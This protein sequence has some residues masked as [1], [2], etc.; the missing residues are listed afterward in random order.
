MTHLLFKDAKALGER[1][2]A[3]TAGHLCDAISERG[4]ARLLLSTGASQLTTIDALV[5]EDVDWS[6]VEVFHLD[7]YVGLPLEHPASFQKYLAERFIARLPGVAAMHYV[8]GLG[9][10]DE[11]IETLTREIRR[12]PIDV[13]LIGIGEN[14][15]IGFN[16]PPADFETEAAFQVVTL[17]SACKAQQ[18]REGWFPD[19]DAVP[20]EAISITVHQIL[21]A[22][23]IL[24]SV[25]YASKATAVQRT[26]ATTE[27]DPLTPASILHRHD[28]WTLL[29]DEESA[30]KLPEE[31][32]RQARE[33]AEGA[34]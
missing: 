18:V 15:H 16:D 23:H 22:R 3:L 13:A 11:A 4:N 9:D 20:N 6:K 30:A 34:A 32:K 21:Q 14:T 7:E 1:A 28:S 5:A 25:P 12:A 33:A 19:N 17:D 26:V 2:A 10:T 8:D 31:T 29:I 27:P 24:S